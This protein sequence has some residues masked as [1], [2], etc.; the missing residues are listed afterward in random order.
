MSLPHYRVAVPVYQTDGMLLR[1]AMLDPLLSSYSWILL[2]EAHERTVNTDILFGVVK[3]AQRRRLE[4][5]RLD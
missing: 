1:E 2:D 3:E 4:Q 5:D